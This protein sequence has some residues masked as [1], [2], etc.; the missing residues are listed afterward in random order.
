MR[1]GGLAA[2]LRAVFASFGLDGIPERPQKLFELD[3][4]DRSQFVRD[5]GGSRRLNHI[6]YLDRIPDR[7]TRDRRTT[8]GSP[9]IHLGA[10]R[11]RARAAKPVPRVTEVVVDAMNDTVN[12]RSIRRRHFLHYSVRLIQITCRQQEETAGT[13]CSRAVRPSD[14]LFLGRGSLL[15][16][17]LIR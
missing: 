9:S 14:F 6:G 4:Q 7:V 11:M 16:Q 15:N 8:D 12:I 17:L 2:E 10:G 5:A 3:R 13:S 1:I